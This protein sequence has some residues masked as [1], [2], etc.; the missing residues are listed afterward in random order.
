MKYFEEFDS[1]NKCNFIK[2]Q[3][4]SKKEI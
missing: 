3:K 1:T 2:R 4:S